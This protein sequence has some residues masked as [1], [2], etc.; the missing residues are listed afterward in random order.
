M[1]QKKEAYEDLEPD[2]IDFDDLENL[3]LFEN[4][5]KE[6]GPDVRKTKVL[7]TA[8]IISVLIIST[9]LV[10]YALVVISNMTNLLENLDGSILNDL[11]SVV[12]VVIGFYFGSKLTE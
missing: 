1:D 6:F 10:L 8:N 3:D 9:Y 2:F 4:K 11:R 5:I 12:L 7:E